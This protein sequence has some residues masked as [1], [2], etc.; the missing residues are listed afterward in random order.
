MPA[1]GRDSG[2]DRHG[3]GSQGLHNAV[4][5]LPGLVGCSGLHAH[6]QTALRQVRA[7]YIRGVFVFSQTSVPHYKNCRSYSTINSTYC[8]TAYSLL[9]VFYWAYFARREQA[10]A[11]LARPRPWL[12]FF[13]EYN[14]A[15]KTKPVP[16]ALQLIRLH[17]LYFVGWASQST[18]QSASR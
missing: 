15:R 8:C 3:G 10:H 6:G 18:R 16:V 13:S 14:R 17:A 4:Y 1:T 9:L 12:A 11:A 5:L 2:V 7:K